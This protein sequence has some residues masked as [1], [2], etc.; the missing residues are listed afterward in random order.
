MH[1]QAHDKGA[2]L[3]GGGTVGSELWEIKKGYPYCLIQFHEQR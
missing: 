1:T 2:Y 3:G